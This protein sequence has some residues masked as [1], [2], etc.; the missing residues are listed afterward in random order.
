ML[1][2]RHLAHQSDSDYS[3][4]VGWCISDC[5]STSAA[6]GANP[7]FLI[8]CSRRLS[9]AASSPPTH[10]HGQNK[11]LLLWQNSPCAPH[12]TWQ[13]SLFSSLGPRLPV[14]L[15]CPPF[16]T[17]W[18]PLQIHRKYA[19]LFLASLF[20][21]KCKARAGFESQIL[22]SYNKLDSVSHTG[23]LSFKCMTIFNP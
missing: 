17:R 16:S 9:A 12:A 10:T 14:H 18:L 2:Q 8:Y 7:S 21:P 19:I 5:H 3:G 6:S 13:T 22:F 1:K 4:Q 15:P 23:I 11:H 20:L